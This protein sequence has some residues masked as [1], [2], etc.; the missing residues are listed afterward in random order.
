[1]NVL[2]YYRGSESLGVGY[3]MAALREAGHR[4]ELVFDPGVDD[5]LFLRAPL[6]RRLNRYDL[7][8][9]KARRFDPDLIAFSVLTNLYPFVKRAARLFKEHFPQ[10]PIIV[11]GQHVTALPEYLMEN[12]DIDIACVGEGEEAL[13]ELVDRMDQGLDVSRVANIWLKRNGKILRN[14]LRPL[15]A[16]LDRL[17][18]PEKEAFH[19]YGCFHDN[20][21]IISSRGCPFRCAFCSAS[22]LHRLYKDKGKYYRRRSMDNV[23]AELEERKARYSFKVVSFHDDT[24]TIDLEWLSAFAPEYRRRIDL[25]FYCLTNPMSTTPEIVEQLKQAGCM[26]VF[27][28]IDSGDPEVRTRILKR[29]MTNERILEAARLIKEAGI[30][31]QVS[32]IFGSPGETAEQMWRTVDMMTTTKPDASAGFV[33]YPYPG[34][35]LLHNAR[36]D[37]LISDEA[38]HAIRE[39]HGSYKQRSVFEHPEADLAFCLIKVIAIHNKVPRILQ[40]LLR[41]VARRRMTRLSQL[42]FIL[43]MPLFFPALS[44]DRAKMTARN[45]WRAQRQD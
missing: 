3:L 7:M 1:M 15:T 8:L 27:L 31:L 28:G 5:T 42:F 16:D 18:F 32:G 44:R 24:F 26:Q 45:L 22:C 11:G 33:C 38:W 21:E 12:P 19:R 17:P 10:V 9:A 20:M 13:V 2:F 25:P 43:S 6:L 37:G 39:G 35:D 34:T 29:S 30:R 41:S 40:L 23:L 14:D 4:A 36:K